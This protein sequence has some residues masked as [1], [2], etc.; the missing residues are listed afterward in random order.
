M[1]NPVWLVSFVEVVNRTTMAEAAR[2]LKITPAAISKHILSLEKHLGFPLLK[3]STRRVGLTSEGILYF[4]EAKNIL[5][6]YKRAEAVLSHS[7]EEPSGLLK[8]LCGPQIGNLYVI[9]YLKDFLNKYPKIRLQVDFTQAVPDLEKENIDVVIGLTSGIPPHWIQRTLMQSRWMFCASPEYLADHGSP[10]KPSDLKKHKIITRILREPNNRIEFKTGES[11]L[12]EPYLYFNDTRAI[13]R[14]ALNHLG[15]AQLHE[16]IIS[17]DLKE[18]RLVEILQKHTEQKK[19][20]PIHISYFPSSHIH[21]KIRCFVDFMIEI[22]K[23]H[24]HLQSKKI[25]SL[26]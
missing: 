15:I 16:Y 4:E 1:F 10:K 20:I 6:A 7:K 22:T 13:R 11:L 5:D 19:T 3:R 8:V 17:G 24:A 21:I 12:F 26:D 25:P 14:A 23:K 18:K 9:P 2:Q